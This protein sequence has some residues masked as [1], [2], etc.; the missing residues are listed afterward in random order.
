MSVHTSELQAILMQMSDEGQSMPFS[1]QP[2]LARR[3]AL[4]G[5]AKAHSNSIFHFD[6]HTSS[7]FEG[8]VEWLS[9]GRMAY[10]NTFSHSHSGSADASRNP[11][12][13][14]P[15]SERG[16]CRARTLTIVLPVSHSTTSDY[17]P[18][19]ASTIA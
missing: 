13:R 12:T 9:M 16:S 15:L 8:R 2:S 14:A 7:A 18:P 1:P 11:R 3:A 17:E 5:S 10:G 4:S 6:R 19:F